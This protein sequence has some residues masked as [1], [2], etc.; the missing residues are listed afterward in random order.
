MALKHDQGIVL[1][2]YPFGEA[3][4]VIVFLSA[5]SGKVRAVAKGVRKTKSR[6][7]GRLEPFSHV[8]L[9]LYE[10]RNLGT[11]TQVSTIETYPNVRNDLDRF[12]A[13]STMVEIADAVAVEDE[14]SAGLLLLLHRGLLAL[15]DGI[16]GPDLLTVYILK[17]ASVLGLAP[18]F[19]D[20]A[21]CGK[22]TGDR[23]SFDAGGV[24]CTNCAPSG[25]YKLRAGVTDRLAVLAATELADLAAGSLAASST[26]P[27]TETLGVAR[28]FLEHHMERKIVSLAVMNE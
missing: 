25:A 12:V 9:V 5:N 8:D 23:F 16:G 19:T 22:P 18:S 6:F 26:I 28:R 20:C 10:G 24:V 21:G 13:A 11:I 3:D 27:P 4:N 14:P 7:G 15:N 17:V 2:T 1:R